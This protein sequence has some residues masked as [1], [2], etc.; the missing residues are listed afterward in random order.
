MIRVAAHAKVNLYLH[1]VGRRA[2]GYHLL[3]SLA[4]FVDLNDTLVV[5]PADDLALAIGGPFADALAGEGDNLVLSAARALANAHG[6]EAR[7]RLTLIKRIPVSAG[8]GGGS[9]DAAA[10]LRALSELWSVA[11]PD[12][13]PLKLGAD[14]PV[15][16]AGRPLFMS[17]IGETLHPAPP[18]PPAFLLLVNPGVAVATKD[19]FR[20]RSGAFSPAA[21]FGE[22]PRDAAHMAGILRGRGNDLTAAAAVLAPAIREAERL[23][24][25]T[26]GCLLAR[27]SGSGATVFGLYAGADEAAKAAASIRRERPA[28][29]SW[30]GAI[31]G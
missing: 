26:E 27:M 11:I 3:D 12:D 10:A 5:A 30:S 29:W 1:V 23:V 16:L 28:W 2:D 24:A 4:V 18:L 13:L 19:V 17:G 8:I 15:C 25:A 20:A 14:V 6:R 7:A 21:A 31:R 9:A 22:A